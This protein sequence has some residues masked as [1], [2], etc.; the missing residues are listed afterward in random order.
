MFDISK[1]KEKDKTV[2]KKLEKLPLLG[3][4][5]NPNHALFTL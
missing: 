2:K 1:K 4:L 5:Y 3:L